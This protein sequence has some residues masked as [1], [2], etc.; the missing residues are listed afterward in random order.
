MIKAAFKNNYFN[1]WILIN[2]SWPKIRLVHIIPPYQELY[3]E[4]SNRVWLLDYL[5][6]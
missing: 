6:V 5:L 3:I 4:L 1:L 2:I